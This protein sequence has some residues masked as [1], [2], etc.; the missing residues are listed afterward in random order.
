MKKIKTKTTRFKNIRIA[1]EWGPETLE[2]RDRRICEECDE[3]YK[4]SEITKIVMRYTDDTK[5]RTDFE[6]LVDLAKELEREYGYSL[7]I[8][9]KGMLLI[10]I[11]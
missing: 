3:S 7:I 1:D 8:E 10:Y 11:W 5:V 6:S 9:P 4:P 2:E